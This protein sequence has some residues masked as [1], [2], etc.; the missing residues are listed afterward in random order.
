VE[1][2]GWLSAEEFEHG[3]AATNLLPGPA[4]T[5]L[6]ILCAWRLRRTAGAVLGGLC[7]ILPGLVVILALSV[8]F[9]SGHPARWV[10]GAAAGCRGGGRRGG[11][12]GGDRAHASELAPGWNR[13]R[14]EDPVV[15]VT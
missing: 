11:P 12:Q 8:L 1:D 6:A 9:F 2:R 10:L 15:L 3:I 14:A 5:Q 7:F 13:P 4:S